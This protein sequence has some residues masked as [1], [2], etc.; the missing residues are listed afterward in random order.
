MKKQLVWFAYA[1]LLFC[2]VISPVCLL[3]AGST[4]ASQEA[5]ELALGYFTITVLATFAF[6]YL[7]QRQMLQKRS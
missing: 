4:G 1:T 7:D 2:L 6:Y 3:Y 5:V